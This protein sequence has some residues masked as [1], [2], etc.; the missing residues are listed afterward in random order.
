[1][2][3]DG[4]LAKRANS[5]NQLFSTMNAK[6][7]RPEFKEIVRLHEM[8]EAE[9]IGHEFKMVRD[10]WQ[11]LAVDGCEN[12]DAIETSGSYGCESDKIEIMGLLT[13]AEAKDDSVVG[14]LSAKNVFKRI[15]SERNKK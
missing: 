3:S 10:G 2:D 9:N 5:L 14:G 4:L 8:L 11:V 15:I 12:F 13:K 7:A 6:Q 1:M